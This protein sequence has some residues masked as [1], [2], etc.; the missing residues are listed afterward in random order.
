MYQHKIS[1]VNEERSEP[2]QLMA[3]TNLDQVKTLHLHN[4]EIVGFAKPESPEVTYMA[5]TNKLNIE[6]MLDIVP[7]N[8]MPK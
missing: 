3:F 5:T 4:G 2:F 8:W 6:E 1:I 7:I